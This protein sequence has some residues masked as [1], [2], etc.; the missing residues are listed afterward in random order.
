MRI[1]P[2][3]PES[4]HALTYSELAGMQP[5]ERIVFRANH[6][7]LVLTIISIP[8]TALPFGRVMLVDAS[9]KVKGYTLGRLGIVE[10]D[11]PWGHEWSANC[12]VRQEE[13]VPA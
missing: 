1:E 2:R 4:A 5:G 11:V 10:Q 7:P 3:N 9:G 13:L 8:Q 6:G 12:C